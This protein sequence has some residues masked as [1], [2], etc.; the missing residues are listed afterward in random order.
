MNDLKAIFPDPNFY[1]CFFTDRNKVDIIKVISSLP[2]KAI[3]IFREYDLTYVGRLNLVCKIQKICHKKDLKLVIGKD[4]TLAKEVATSSVH[5]S[6]YDNFLQDFD[7]IKENFFVT[8]SFHSKE[9]ILKYQD[10]NFDIRFLSPIFK[11][12]SHERQKP[13]GIEVLRE[14][15]E[16]EGVKICP[17]GGI[18]TENIEKL[19]NLNITGIAGIDLFKFFY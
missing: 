10:L 5:F 8:C 13:L 6:D 16:G 14:L 2:K 15:V 3:V 11:T 19:Q 4:I 17:L 9:S 7:E 12:T 18:N 1:I